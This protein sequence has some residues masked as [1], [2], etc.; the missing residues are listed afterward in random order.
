MNRYQYTKVTGRRTPTFG[1]TKYPVVPLSSSDIYVITQ[2]EDRYDQLAQQYY[3]DSSLW[4]II[5]CS[6]AGLKQNSY[7]PPIGVQIRIPQDISRVISKF[8]ILNER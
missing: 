7:Y 1:T 3:G 5:S 6:N 4:W 2:E 8:R